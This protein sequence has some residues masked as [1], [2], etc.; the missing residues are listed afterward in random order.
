MF[1]RFIDDGIP[2]EVNDFNRMVAFIIVANCFIY[3][4][5]YSK[6]FNGDKYEIEVVSVGAQ[7]VSSNSRILLASGVIS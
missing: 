2:Y 7:D 5:F 6:Q 4:G 1:N 3:L